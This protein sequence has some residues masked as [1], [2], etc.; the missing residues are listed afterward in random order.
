MLA[1]CFRCSFMLQTFFLSFHRKP[2]LTATIQLL[3]N[4]GGNP[5]AST[6][7]MPVLF[8]AVKAADTNAVKALLS[9]GADTSICLDSKVIDI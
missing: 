2:H 1:K 5:N 8:F 6:L 3:L 7:P 4:R 9:K